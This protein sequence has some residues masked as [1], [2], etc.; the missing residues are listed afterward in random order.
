[1][2]IGDRPGQAAIAFALVLAVPRR[3]RQPDLEEVPQAGTLIEDGA[4]AADRRIDRAYRLRVRTGGQRLDEQDRRVRQAERLEGP[5]LTWRNSGGHPRRHCQGGEQDV[6]KAYRKAPA[7]EASSPCKDPI[8]QW[9]IRAQ[10][11]C[12]LIWP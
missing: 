5:G 2:R 6:P 9:G 11:F 4:N 1:V 3:A 7:H 8:K 10:L 12:S